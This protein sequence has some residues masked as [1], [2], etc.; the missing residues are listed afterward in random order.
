MI[1]RLLR[2]LVLAGACAASVAA[3]AS[4]A[5]ARTAYDGNWSVL[6]VTERGSCDRA[7]RYGVQ[8][9]NGN[10]TYD[11]G[12]LVSLGGRVAPNGAVQVV[13]QGGGAVANG[14]GKLSRTAGRGTW[15]GRTGNDIC[16][17][18]WQAE[19]RG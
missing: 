16:T 12:G 4:T 3:T 6:I 11:G 18:Y 14:L 13:V 9:N 10:V 1:S 7:Y 2:S 17:G 15:S 19:R 8:I 5:V